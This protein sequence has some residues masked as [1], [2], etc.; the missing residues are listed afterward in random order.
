[1]EQQSDTEV[2]VTDQC[3]S[4][5]ELHLSSTTNVSGN[6]QDFLNWRLS[7][8]MSA[9]PIKFSRKICMK[10]DTPRELLWDDYRL[11]AEKIGLDKDDVS[12]LGQQDNKTEFILQKFDA[13]EDPS[14]RRFKE[15][16]EEMGRN[17]VVTVIDDWVLYEWSKQN[18]NSPSIL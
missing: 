15:I 17:D 5:T 11:L 14:I 6:P 4:T 16:L 1:L 2:T 10:L 8:R 7:K 3:T 13:Q 18:D 12:W 9:I